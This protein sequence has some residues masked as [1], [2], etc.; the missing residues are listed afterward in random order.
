MPT[1]IRRRSSC[2][3]KVKASLA[4][5][6]FSSSGLKGS[7]PSTQPASTTCGHSRPLDACSVESVTTFWSFSRSLFPPLCWPL[8]AMSLLRDRMVMTNAADTLRRMAGAWSN[9]GVI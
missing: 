8:A 1:Y 9:P 7:M 6:P 2:S 3:R 4:T 5:A